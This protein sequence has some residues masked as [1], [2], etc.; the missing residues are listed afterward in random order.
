MVFPVAAGMA[1]AVAVVRA[2]G[3]RVIGERA[4]QQR[5]DGCV[6]VSARAAVQADARL[7]E[8]HPRS[9]ADPSA[10]EDLRALLPQEGRQRAVAAPVGG[11]DARRDHLPVLRI[12]QFEC[13]RM[14]EMRKDLSVLVCHRDLHIL[15]SSL[16]FTGTLRRDAGMAGGGSLSLLYKV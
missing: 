16:L 9:A 6:R 3:V 15:A 2:G 8:R 13:L 1:F 10:D 14:A 5:L 12:V 4:A 7:V 11:D